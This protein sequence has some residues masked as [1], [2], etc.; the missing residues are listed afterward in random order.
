MEK[1]TLGID[2]AG[3]GPILG[4]MVMA[5]VSVTTSQ[6]RRLTKLG[7]RDSKSFGTPKKAKIIRRQ[8]YDHILSVATHVEVRVVS[9][10]T[11]DV[12]VA[13]KQLNQLERDVASEMIQNTPP[14]DKI[15]ADGKTLFQALTKSFSHLVALN[16]AESHHVAVAAASIVAKH[17]RDQQFEKIA[18]KY[19]KEFGELRGGG[20]VNSGTK[21]FLISYAK[22]YHRLPQETRTSWPCTYAKPW[23]TQEP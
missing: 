2:E 19:R 12:N 20:Y 23:L 13:N 14:C 11:I 6:A 17:I 22:K 10:K 7:V 16:Q 21:N 18:K 3:R 1:T 9:V 4:P 5:A 8:L 15:V